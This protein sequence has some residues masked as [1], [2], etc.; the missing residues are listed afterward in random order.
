MKKLLFI[1]L[2]L[3]INY[4]IVAQE[5]LMDTTQNDSTKADTTRLKFGGIK[6]LI[7]TGEEEK[8]SS[9]GEPKKEK[10]CSHKNHWAGIDVGIAGYLSPQQSFG[11]TYEN[12]LFELDYS[13]SRTWNINFIEKDFKLIRNYAGIVTGMGIS[14]HRYHF[15]EKDIA[16]TPD[17]IVTTII[18]ISANTRK[19]FLSSSYFT[20]PLLFEFNTHQNPEKSFHI[21]AG[22][23]G[24]Y[25]IG[26]K[27][28]SVTESAG[29]KTRLVVRDNYNLS[30]F[31]LSAT[32]RF[33]FG[34]LNLFATYGIIEL[35]NKDKGPELFPISAGITLIGF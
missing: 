28:V 9:T 5:T 23:I 16:L 15:N 22:V 34:G 30:P 21:A 8:E 11:M 26:S 2:I 14:L 7:I 33:G 3:A 10:T 1:P 29:E 12:S 31:N 17:T 13:R 25:H 24:G 19:H 27:A 32:V 6:I 20:I 18:P 35:F 4:S